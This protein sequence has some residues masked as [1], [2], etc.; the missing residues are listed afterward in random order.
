VPSGR[1]SLILRP[2]DGVMLC[3]PAEDIHG[4]KHHYAQC[5]IRMMWKM[6]MQIPL[7]LPCSMNYI[8][9]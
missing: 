9:P 2:K 4:M 6:T 8:I 7:G 3:I 5:L 1:C